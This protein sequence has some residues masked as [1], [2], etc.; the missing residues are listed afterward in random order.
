MYTKLCYNTT[1]HQ[2]TKLCHLL[3]EEEICVHSAFISISK[4]PLENVICCL[5]FI[6]IGWYWP[7]PLVSHL[8][9][10][11]EANLRVNTP[12]QKSRAEVCREKRWSLICLRP[13]HFWKPMPSLYSI[14][15]TLK[16]IFC[17][18]NTNHSKW[19]TSY[20]YVVLFHHILPNWTF[21]VTQWSGF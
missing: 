9:T 5:A 12:D 8:K 13:L 17:Y 6:Y 1:V 7:H 15:A 21:T 14:E 19:Y 4:F 18:C 11:N 16:L 2:N 20:I 10:E 3:N